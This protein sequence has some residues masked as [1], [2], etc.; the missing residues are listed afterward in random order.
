VSLLYHLAN[1]LKTC[2]PCLGK[3][4]VVRKWYTVMDPERGVP[5]RDFNVCHCCVR[6]IETLLPQLA[7]R[8]FVRSD[9][10]DLPKPCKLRFDSPR[11]VHYFDALEQMADN[12]KTTRTAPDPR[13][14]VALVKKYLA[15]PECPKG[16]ELQNERWHVIRELPEF[17]V[18]PE[19]FADVVVPE[20][21]QRKAIPSMF[22]RAR[23]LVP[24][25][26]CQLHSPRMREVFGRAV[27]ADDYL[28]L[29]TKARER[30][31][32]ELGRRERREWE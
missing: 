13:E 5:I 24:S 26:S 18:C 27:D 25:A 21:E 20:L 3:H 16:E 1:V 14:F 23:Q 29:A 22:S 7:G 6:C 32:M 9:Q 4:A 17:T 10:R 8:V 19:C 15:L 30:R 31:K 2:E 12:A 11:F 28:L